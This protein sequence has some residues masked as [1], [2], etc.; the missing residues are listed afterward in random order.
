MPDNIFQSDIQW[1]DQRIKAAAVYCSDGR[2]GEQW[3]DFLYNVLKLPCYDRLGVPGGPGALIQRDKTAA[4]F[5]A[6]TRQMGFLLDAHDINRVVL[7]QHIGCAFYGVYLGV[8]EDQREQQQRDD[9]ARAIE[10]LLNLAPH[11][12]IDSYV[13]RVVDGLVR[14]YPVQA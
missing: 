13:A 8:P 11:I 7:I 2:F 9:L 3:D 5:D 1:T 6:A 14:F 4:E 10:H 12:T